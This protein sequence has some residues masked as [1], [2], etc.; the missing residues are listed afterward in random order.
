VNK[1]I[2]RDPT[3]DWKKVLNKWDDF[4]EKKSLLNIIHN[5]KKFIS[6]PRA[7]ERGRANIIVPGTLL[8]L[9]IDSSRKNGWEIT[10]NIKQGISKDY[11]I[12]EEK[13]FITKGFL[14][15]PEA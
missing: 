4:S 3:K 13:T 15:F 2:V 8:T 6:E 11:T 7:Y 1:P 12:I 14:V 9:K 5:K 10:E